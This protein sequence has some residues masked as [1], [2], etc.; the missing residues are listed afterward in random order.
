MLKMFAMRQSKPEAGNKFYN[1][2]SRGGYSTCVQGSPTDSGCNVLA[3]C[4]GY[5][6]GRFNEIYG[7]MKYPSLNCNAENFIE[8]AK[9]IGLQVVNYPV[10]GGIMVFQKGATLSGS[11]GAGH[12][13]IVEDIYDNNT[14]YTSESGWNSSAFWNSKRSNSN[15][16]WGLGAGYSFRGCIVNPAVGVVTT[17]RNGGG[18]GGTDSSSGYTGKFKEGDQVIINGKLYPS[19]TSANATGSVSNKSTTITRVAKNTAHPYNTTG[20]IGWMNESDI[21]LASTPTPTPTPT[22]SPGGGVAY[23]VVSGDTVSGICQKF[24]GHSTQADWDLIKNA[25]GLD[26]K[27]TIYAG[28]TLTIPNAGGST[29]SSDEFNV[30]DRVVIT[31]GYASSATSGSAPNTKMKGA[32]RY[33]TKI[34]SG[35]NYPYQL[36][37]NP[38][39]ISGG[40]TTGF[41]SKNSIRKA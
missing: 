22:P 35:A 39:D 33:I 10:M 17:G 18:G 14:I 31:G 19:S 34:H 40:N 6:C 28:Q 21:R 27:Y 5:A 20:D 8:R 11:D 9:S 23:K 38:G 2:T 29:P 32:T 24:Y 7:S 41:A 30:G 26:S 16:R 37:A 12:V 15:G 25:N 3:N 36:G 4:V 1:T 13:C